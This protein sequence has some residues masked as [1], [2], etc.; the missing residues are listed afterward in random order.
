MSRRVRVPSPFG[1]KPAVR[2]KARRSLSRRTLAAVLA[3]SLLLPGVF[4]LAAPRAAQ[5]Q[6]TY[7][8]D[9]K[10]V[11]QS[12][13]SYWS[14]FVGGQRNWN[15]TGSPNA[16]PVSAATTTLNFT[17]SDTRANPTSVND[18][19]TF[20]LN[21]LTFAA[22]AHPYTLSGNFLSFVANGAINPVITNNA[23]SLQTINNILQIASATTL[24][25]SGVGDIA[26]GGNLD[27]AG[28]LTK[29]GA[30]TLTLTGT[31][32][33]TGGTTINNGTLLLGS[34][35][36]LPSGGDVS[37]AAANGASTLNTG[38]AG[39]NNTV[40]N[41]TFNTG[42]NNQAGI[43][44]AGSLTLNG[45]VTYAPATNFT[46]PP[47]TITAPL[48]L[49]AGNHQ[50]ASNGNFSSDQYDTILGGG[51]SGAGSLEKM[52][53]GYNLALE[54]TNL[55]T[56]GTTVTSGYLYLAAT[57][58]LPTSGAVTV[59]GGILTLN[60]LT[61]TTNGVTVTGGNYSQTIG[62][63]AGS[64][65][66]QVYL[67]S[68]TL[69]MGTDNASTTYA[70]TFTG[71]GALVKTGAGTLT[72]SG[73]SQLAAPITI[74]GGTL[75]VTGGLQSATGMQLVNVLV[76]SGATFAG[77]GAAATPAAAQI[78]LNSGGFLRPGDARVANSTGTLFAGG[79]NWQSGGILNFQLGAT[80]AN[81]DFLSMDNGALTKG[82]A[83]GVYKFDF[84]GTGGITL[85]AAYPLIEFNSAL[86]T[87]F[88]ATD[89]SYTNLNSPVMFSFGPAVNGHSTLYATAASV[90]EGGSGVLM[91][92][93][94]AGLGGGAWV[95]R[96]RK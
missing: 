95:L 2:K 39:T 19:G 68:A 41:I 91:L 53:D 46:A 52:G 20:I 90:P 37:I 66:G 25:V 35:T 42:G 6:T 45:N 33:Y 57:N 73:V 78:T 21:A 80:P 50:F 75:N 9:G 60:P 74:N 22:G 3:P 64:P 4:L 61:Q 32:K 14:S 77:T 59:N 72:L 70:G 92:F 44:G 67:G 55:Y 1:E 30:D 87:T 76:N 16:A 94:A 96:R 49:A 11:T 48:I 8:W 23:S 26:L 27:G 31:D 83:G 24:T 86:G 93:A 69:T 63:L 51:I 88:A 65:G 28:A 47:A 82:S 12:G 43:T 54:G 89:F 10:D 38:A 58:T 56:G 29:T 13:N 85:G 81:T 84:A 79:L 34:N 36:A 71:T 62:S 5:A 17:A 7:N 15:T 40:R 18:L